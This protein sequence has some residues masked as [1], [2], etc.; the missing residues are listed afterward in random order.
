MGAAV[1]GV[2]LF[3]ESVSPSRLLFMTLLVVSIVGL[4]LTSVA[5]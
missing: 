5:S 1:G 2:V 4:R 3:G